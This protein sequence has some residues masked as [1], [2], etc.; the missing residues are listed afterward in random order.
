M[1]SR[2]DVYEER[3]AVRQRS[4]ER[5][6]EAGTPS[7][8]IRSQE[9]FQQQRG[10]DK[11]RQD[12]CYEKERQKYSSKMDFNRRRQEDDRY[13]E[14]PPETVP[15]RTFINRY[16]DRP[17][18]YRDYD[19]ERR[20]EDDKR[21]LCEQKTSR[22]FDTHRDSYDYEK[23]RRTVRSDTKD[24]RYDEKYYDKPTLDRNFANKAHSRRNLER[25]DRNS[26][27][28]RE[29]EFR[30]RDRYSE[31]ERDSGLSVAD[32]ETSTVSGR[33]NYLR[34][35]KVTFLFFYARRISACLSYVTLLIHY[36]C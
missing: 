4:I 19:R 20:Y 14:Y 18:D 7:S 21:R 32:G 12:C 28:S 1:A 8:R 15:T 16:G 17:P 9:N 31:R 36:F 10:P 34:V 5:S 33:S 11:T 2:H 22:S 24:K 30:E 26:V 13:R 29:D 27:V 3:H 6:R 23:C 35:V 25:C